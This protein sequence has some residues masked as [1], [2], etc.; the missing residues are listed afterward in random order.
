MLASRHSYLGSGPARVSATYGTVGQ[1]KRSRVEHVITT[2]DVTGTLERASRLTTPKEA[3]P[4][5]FYR[6]SVFR[7]YMRITWWAGEGLLF[8]GDRLA[9]RRLSPPTRN[10][11]NFHFPLLAILS[12]FM[13]DVRGAFPLQIVV[14]SM[15][16]M[17][18]RYRHA[19]VALYEPGDQ[20]R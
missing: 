20:R 1:D 9:S 7:D 12:R 16:F 8:L 15:I 11:N 4:G 18:N 13:P 2:C 19:D 10:R 3:V 14:G 6:I 17:T 5:F